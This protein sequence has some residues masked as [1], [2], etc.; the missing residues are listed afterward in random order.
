[1]DHFKPSS[2]EGPVRGSVE[3]AVGAMEDETTSFADFFDRERDRLFGL[4]VLVTGIDRRPK[5]WHRTR[6]SLYGNDGTA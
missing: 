4:L 1:M 2:M 6:S 5:T 3:I